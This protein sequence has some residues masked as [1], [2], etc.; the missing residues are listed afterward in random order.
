MSSI[1]ANDKGFKVIHMSQYEF[2]FIGGQSLCDGCNTV[3]KDGYYIA[4]LNYA[5][6]NAR[7]TYKY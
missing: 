2:I 4:V 6:C 1:V 3:M 7:G 5:Y